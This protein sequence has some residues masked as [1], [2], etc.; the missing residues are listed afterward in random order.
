[1]IDPGLREEHPRSQYK[2][3]NLAS[4][5]NWGTQQVLSYWGTGRK[6]RGDITG[7]LLQKRMPRV[8]CAILESENSKFKFQVCTY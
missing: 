1:M 2:V 6:G 3:R 4:N 8:K 7:Y 5:R